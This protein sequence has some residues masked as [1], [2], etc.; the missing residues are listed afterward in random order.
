MNQPVS[1]CLRVYNTGNVVLVEFLQPHLTGDECISMVRQRFT[2][3]LQA[4][5]RARVVLNLKG[6][7]YLSSAMLS[8][9]LDLRSELLANGGQLR[10]AGVERAVH[11]IFCTTNLDHRFVF[12]D[13]A[14]SAIGSFAGTAP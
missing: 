13:D 3:M 7:E 6:V 12:H 14:R 5:P 4:L 1:P 10:L 9:L 8:E 2:L 11:D